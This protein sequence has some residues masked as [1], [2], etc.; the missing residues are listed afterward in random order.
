ML[1]ITLSASF[2]SSL[3]STEGT[4]GGGGGRAG[5]AG[6]SY[7]RYGGY[8]HGDDPYEYKGRYNPHHDNGHGDVYDYNNHYDYYPYEYDPLPSEPLQEGPKCTDIQECPPG[9]YFSTEGCA[10]V[11][12]GT[13]TTPPQK[14]CTL[15]S[16][17]CNRRQHLNLDTCSCECVEYSLFI[18]GVPAIP[19]IPGRFV[20]PK[21]GD[22]GKSKGSRRKSSKR[23]RRGVEDSLVELDNEDL[24]RW[25]LSL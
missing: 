14:Y 11:S 4:G 22:R 1:I 18:P 20:H 12:E 25:V 13:P 16:T 5:Y 15:S 23:R 19:A 6:A 2:I 24:M 10:C 17:V 7:N 9:Y 8:K 3:Q 21:K